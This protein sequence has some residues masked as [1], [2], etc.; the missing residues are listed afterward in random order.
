MVC[1]TAALACLLL[2]LQL[3]LQQP[4]FLLQ[5]SKGVPVALVAVNRLETIVLAFFVPH[6]FVDFGRSDGDDSFERILLVDVMMR[7]TLNG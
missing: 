4:H 7:Q 2:T 1:L 6:I 3:L 5:R